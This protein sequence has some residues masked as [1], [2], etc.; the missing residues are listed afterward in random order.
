MAERNLKLSNLHKTFIMLEPCGIESYPGAS[1]F[2][3]TALS[4]EMR[5]VCPEIELDMPLDFT[6]V[7]HK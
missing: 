2:P 3:R 1:A 5:L 6:V 4:A 7:I